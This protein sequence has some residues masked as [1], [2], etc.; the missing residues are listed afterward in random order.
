MRLGIAEVIVK[1]R[2]VTCGFDL[3]KTTRMSIFRINYSDPFESDDSRNQMILKPVF[4]AKYDY[5]KSHSFDFETG[6]SLY[7]TENRFD[8]SDTFQIFFVNLGC[9]YNF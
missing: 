6:V 9:Y 2:N 4:R 8:G 3:R 5:R 1:S 7:D